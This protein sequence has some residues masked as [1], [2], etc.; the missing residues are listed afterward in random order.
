MELGRINALSPIQAAA[1]PD[2]VA[3]NKLAG[4]TRLFKVE[5]SSFTVVP[6][7]LTAIAGINKAIHMVTAEII[8]IHFFIQNPPYEFYIKIVVVNAVYF[9]YRKLIKRFLN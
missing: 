7:A 8:D 4:S 3:V 1:P 6:D 2:A 5:Q 9:K